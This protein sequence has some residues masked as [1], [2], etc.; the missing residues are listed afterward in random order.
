MTSRH[1]KK[2]KQLHQQQA[3]T[4]ASAKKEPKNDDDDDEASLD[5]GAC[6]LCHCCLDFSDRAA[7]FQQDRMEDYDEKEKEEVSSQSSFYFRPTDPYLPATLYDPCNAL[8]YCDS[9]DRLYHQKCHFVPLLL[10]PRGSWHCLLCQTQREQDHRDKQH[11]KQQRGGKRMKRTSQQPT[12]V[13]RYDAL[14]RSPPTQPFDL[15]HAQE[16]AWELSAAHAKALLYKQ[17]FAKLRQYLQTQLA[18]HRQ[19]ATALDALTSTRRNRNYFLQHTNNSKRPISQELV[20][21]LMKL[22]SAKWNIRKLLLNVEAIRR[23]TPT[24]YQLLEEAS[25][26]LDETNHDFVVRVLFPFGIDLLQYRRVEPRTSEMRLHA[27]DDALNDAAAKCVATPDSTISNH[28][29]QPIP[30]EIAIVGG[31]IASSLV[32]AKITTRKGLRDGRLASTASSNAAPEIHSNNHH[33]CHANHH[34]A[35]K[36]LK[37]KITAAGDDD[38]SGVSL[39]DL[40]CCVC[41][42]YEATDDNDMVLCDGRGCYRAYHQDCVVPR[43]TIDESDDENDWFCPICV[44][45]A[46]LVGFVQGEYMGDDWEQRRHALAIEGGRK[47]RVVAVTDSLKSWDGVDEVFPDSQ[48][49]FEAASQLKSGVRNAL[50]RRFLALVLGEDEP[51]DGINED[52]MNDDDDDDEEDFD[53]EQ[54]EADSVHVDDAVDE[55]DRNSQASLGDLSSVELHIDKEEV[56]ALSDVDDVSD[57]IVN[58]S[59]RRLSKRLRKRGGT[60]TESSS[61]TQISGSGQGKIDTANIVAGKRRR[62][63]ID[64]IKLNE[65]LFGD[66]SD[67]ALESIDDLEDYI[68]TPPAV[69]DFSKDSESDDDDDNGTEESV[70]HE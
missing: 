50:T 7:F 57:V 19:A 49:E 47:K 5:I 18:N 34:W 68:M 12:H 69:K 52:A 67:E 23:S 63:S 20:Q 51:A 10:L 21:V 66:A 22:C 28:Y 27:S 29:H 25:L 53:P 45:I 65:A 35:K 54:G 31:T 42:S 3:E 62:K 46:E 14:F 8:V 37:E 13:F 38:A 59:N 11:T 56:A 6:C 17:Q 43:V 26:K 48:R 1:K 36:M 55:S 40:Q 60:S 24:A 41:L 30:E 33:L 2:K 9:C 32:A 39:E 15:I 61:V 44:G 4:N 16:V 70:S 64:Y 58:G